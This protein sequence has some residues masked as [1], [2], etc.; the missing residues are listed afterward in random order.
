MIAGSE[1]PLAPNQGSEKRPYS[2]QW[3]GLEHYEGRGLP[4]PLGKGVAMASI[5]PRRPCRTAAGNAGQALISV[6]DQMEWLSFVT[7]APILLEFT[8]FRVDY[9][10]PVILPDGGIDSLLKGQSQ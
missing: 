8:S 9:S 1:P 10:G 5:T 7:L 6:E 2:K 3:R 4:W